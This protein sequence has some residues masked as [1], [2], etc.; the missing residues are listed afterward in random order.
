MALRIGLIEGGGGLPF[1]QKSS[2]NT[3]E[4]DRY[5]GVPLSSGIRLTHGLGSIPTCII[6]LDSD[7][8]NTVP[9]N[10][11][12]ADKNT[13]IGAFYRRAPDDDT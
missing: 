2:I 3:F 10:D 4:R 1:A 9:Y 5:F 7:L 8:S 13:F 11:G 6:V 12:T